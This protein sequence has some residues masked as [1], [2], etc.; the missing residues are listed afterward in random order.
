MKKFFSEFKK[1]ITRGN[2]IDMAVGVIVG[3]SFTAIVNGMSNFILKPI[4]NALLA[5]IFGKN[6]LSDLHTFLVTAYVKDDLG[7]DT[8]VIDLANSI[9]IDWGSFINAVINF[10]LVA[11]VLF[12]IVKIINK[13]REEQLKFASELME[14]KLTRA[15][16]KELKGM[17]I[18]VTDK[19]AVA[20]YF[21][22]KAEEAKAAEE[23]AKAEAEEKARLEREANPTTEDL[24]KKIITLIENK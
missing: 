1:F 4:I 8:E 20:S 13:L 15:Q 2:V 16:K 18:K 7:K 12:S 21:A 24:L 6:S 9:Y 17:G 10:F 3:S 5:L 23:A 19:A 11:F 22:K 14:G